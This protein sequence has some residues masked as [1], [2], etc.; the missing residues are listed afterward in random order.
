[1]EKIYVLTKTDS[2]HNKVLLRAYSEED[3]G[4]QDRNLCQEVDQCYTYNLYVLDVYPYK[5][6]EE[7]ND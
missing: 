5:K 7:T 4:E 6:E 3:R 2:D 1:M